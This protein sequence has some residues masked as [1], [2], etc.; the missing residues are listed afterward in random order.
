MKKKA[1]LLA[2]LLLVAT[3]TS[4]AS[5]GPVLKDFIRNMENETADLGGRTV[6]FGVS[7]I[8]EDGLI[9]LQDST[10][11]M[12]D[13][14]RKLIKNVEERLHCVV[15]QDVFDKD[16]L[17]ASI[18]S[19]NCKFDLLYDHTGNQIDLVKAGLLHDLNT[20]EVLDLSNVNKWGTAQD[21]LHRTYQGKV[22]GVKPRS[23]ASTYTSLEGVMMVNDSLIKTF[24]QP[25]PKELFEQGNWTFDYFTDYVVKVSDMKADEPIYGMSYY[26]GQLSQLPLTAIFAN[27]SSLLQNSNSGSL[28]FNLMKDPK[29]VAALDWAQEVY[30]TGVLKEEDA[31]TNSN[32]FISGRSSLWLGGAW[33]G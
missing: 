14:Q 22:F 26:N 32:T 19:F 27:G 16:A 24:G 4:C 28:S 18:G 9:P 10:S 2:I 11:A 1:L 3:V 5:D 21:Q 20:F 8:T 31:A 12:S 25:T 29:A 7:A 30:E 17:A 23:A 15:E 6:L 13:A 33:V